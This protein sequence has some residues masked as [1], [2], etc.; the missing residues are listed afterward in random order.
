MPG[1]QSINRAEMEILRSF[2][3]PNTLTDQSYTK[4]KSNIKIGNKIVKKEKDCQVKKIQVQ[5]EQD[6]IQV[7]KTN[8]P[9]QT[10]TEILT[11]EIFRF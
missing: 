8:N 5:I 3:K 4:Y 11:R 2:G 7:F 1:R 6:R 9:M 10:N